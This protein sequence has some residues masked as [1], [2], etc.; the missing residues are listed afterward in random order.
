MDGKDANYLDGETSTNGATDTDPTNAD[1]FLS[2]NI[3]ECSCKRGSPLS[4][5][6][7]V[8][9]IK[10]YDGT[11]LPRYLLLPETISGVC[12]AK[13]GHS[14]EQVC[15]INDNEFVLELAE[16]TIVMRIAQDI[17]QISS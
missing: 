12:K 14:P 1:D 7:L 6:Y 9:R 15:P 3:R 4:S 11:P 5:V 13:T 10:Q 16:D 17:W 8:V 2:I